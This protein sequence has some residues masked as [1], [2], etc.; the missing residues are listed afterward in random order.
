[1]STTKSYY[2]HVITK[3]EWK[4]RIDYEYSSY[5]HAHKR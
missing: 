3:D 4:G 1:M 2:T 5:V